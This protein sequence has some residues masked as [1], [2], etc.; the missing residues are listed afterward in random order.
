MTALSLMSWADLEAEM[1][2]VVL[3]RHRVDHHVARRGRSADGERMGW[4]MSIY[5]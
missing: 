3:V 4:Q 2:Q 1:E 5:G